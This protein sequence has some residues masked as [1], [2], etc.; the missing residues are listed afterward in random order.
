[1]LYHGSS[2]KLFALEPRP[3]R[4]INYEEA[5]FATNERVLALAFIPKLGPELGIGS[6]SSTS[7]GVVTYSCILLVENSPGVFAKMAVEGFI[8]TVSSD[9][10]ESDPRLGMKRHEF[11]NKKVVDVVNIEYVPNV[12]EEINKYEP[13]IIN[14]VTFEKSKQWFVDHGV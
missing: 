6:F 1:M 14:I 9:G 13:E 4:V 11:I 10:F 8:H 5:V 12:W 2:K 3:S 7:D